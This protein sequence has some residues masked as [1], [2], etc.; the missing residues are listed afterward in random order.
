[1]EIREINAKPKNT[2]AADK[3]EALLKKKRADD[4]K[5]VKGM[6]EFT[7]AGGGWLDFAYRFYKGAPIQCIKIY[8]G[9]IVDLPMGIVRHLNNTYKK[10]RT[11]GSGKL[12]ANGLPEGGMLQGSGKVPTS[13]M[14]TSRCR[15]VPM[16]FA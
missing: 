1:M 16:D 4:D 15:F 3:F 6:F 11:F 7:D 9:E 2:M 5:I 14:K 13:F 12:G 8:H 10:I